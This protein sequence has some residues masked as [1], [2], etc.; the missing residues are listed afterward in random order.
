[1]NIKDNR[2]LSANEITAFIGQVQSHTQ[3][4]SI[5]SEKVCQLVKFKNAHHIPTTLTLAVAI[6]MFLYAES[7]TGSI[8]Q[9]T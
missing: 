4:V 8:M 6:Q 2:K 1:M 9:L 7:S 5:S 3:I